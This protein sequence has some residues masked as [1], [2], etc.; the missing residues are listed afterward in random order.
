MGIYISLN[1][2][3][4][5]TF[6]IS[7]ILSENTHCHC[8]QIRK[9]IHQYIWANTAWINMQCMWCRNLWFLQDC[10]GTI[11]S[12]VLFFTIS[13]LFCIFG[14]TFLKNHPKVVEIWTWQKNNRLTENCAIT[15][16]QYPV[17]YNLPSNANWF[18]LYWP[19]TRPKCIGNGC[20]F[21]FGYHGN[22]CIVHKFA[23]NVAYSKRS[24]LWL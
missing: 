5:G 23:Q 19:C 4:P 3:S 15:T 11:F 24:R 10:D 12:S 8:N 17:F 9:C 22:S 18:I 21:W 13:T 7:H 2:Q 16:L 6:R 20:I 1:S 14:S